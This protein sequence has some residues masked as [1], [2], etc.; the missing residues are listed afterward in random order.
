MAVYSL[1]NL[2]YQRTKQSKT[3]GLKIVL[4]IWIPTVILFFYN[5]TKCQKEV[6]FSKCIINEAQNNDWSHTFN[7]LNN[8]TQLFICIF[9]F[10]EHWRSDPGH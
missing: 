3:A 4:H 1:E 7:F 8:F 9:N 2:V 5:H 10:V 6:S